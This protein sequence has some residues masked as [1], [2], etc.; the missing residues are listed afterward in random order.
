MHA[1]VIKYVYVYNMVR[2][3]KELIVLFVNLRLLDMSFGSP[4]RSNFY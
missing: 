1:C 3:K 2:K 4:K